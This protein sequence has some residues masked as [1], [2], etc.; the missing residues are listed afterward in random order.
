MNDRPINEKESLEIITSMIAQT[1]KRYMLGDGNIMLLWGYLTVGVSAL[2]WGLLA[3]TNNPAVNWLW[4]LIWIIGGIA[5]PVMVRKQTV[6][7]GVKTYTDKL[8]SRLWTI[9]GWSAISIS[10]ACLGLMLF[11]GLDP[12]AAMFMF[13]LVIIPFAEIVNGLILEE[14]SYIWGGAI[15]L[16]GG[17]FLTCCIAGDVTL[18][19]AWVL[20]LFIGSFI[21]MMI[22][23]G[24]IINHKAKSHPYENT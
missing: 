5:T 18:K 11:K 15:G 22:I 23:P 21:C 24:H 19:A 6:R 16:S 3:I 14:S 12:W 8:I 9:V 17:I 2:I 4:Y 10:F 20:P 13:A 1:K 7:N